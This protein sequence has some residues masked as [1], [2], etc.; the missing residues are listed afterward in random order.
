MNR[1]ALLK[2]DVIEE[3]FHVLGRWLV[4]IAE[5]VRTP[6]VGITTSKVPSNKLFQHVHDVKSFQNRYL[7]D[8]FPIGIPDVFNKGR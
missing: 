5:D 2:L 3:C 4:D 6:S 7:H 1:A 8:L